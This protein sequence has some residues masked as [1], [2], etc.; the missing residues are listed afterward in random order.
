[1]IASRVDESS[2]DSDLCKDSAR[3]VNA[4]FSWAW[5]TLSSSPILSLQCVFAIFQPKHVHKLAA[6]LRPLTGP[7]KELSGSL[8]VTPSNL[9]L[10]RDHLRDDSHIPRRPGKA[11]LFH[12]PVSGHELTVA[13]GRQCARRHRGAF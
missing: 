4:F 11:S 9:G 1:M 6:L 5:L 2:F 12:E 3:P 10:S 13:S 7:Q 8:C